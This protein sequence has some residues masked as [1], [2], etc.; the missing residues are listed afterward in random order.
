[1]QIQRKFNIIKNKQIFFNFGVYLIFT[2]F[3]YFFVFFFFNFRIQKF[4]LNFGV[5]LQFQRVFKLRKC[6][7]SFGDFLN[8]QVFYICDV[9]NFRTFFLFSTF[10]YGFKKF[11]NFT[12]FSVPTFGDAYLNKHLI[13]SIKNLFK[14]K[15]QYL[16]T[17]LLDLI[18]SLIENEI[19]N[20]V[21]H[22]FK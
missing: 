11:R 8:V 9:L 20:K 22:Y 21:T 13:T 15:K 18:K 16:I 10:I 19:N 7:F 17:F 3:F 4:L 14:N 5:L 1:M 6:F 12:N 2:V